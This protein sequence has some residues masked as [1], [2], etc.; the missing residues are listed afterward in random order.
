[1]FKHIKIWERYYQEKKFI[2]MKDT[3][4][5]VYGANNEKV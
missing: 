2:G 1:M 3:K 5:G 4:G